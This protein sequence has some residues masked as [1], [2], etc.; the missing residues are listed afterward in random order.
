MIRIKQHEVVSKLADKLKEAEEDLE[1]GHLTTH[2]Y[3]SIED[4]LFT[5]FEGFIRTLNSLGYI[6]Q[7]EED[8]LYH[9]MKVL[10]EVF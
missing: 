3:L 4:S 7:M 8:D 5:D 10:K 9:D 2:D 1:C 6:S